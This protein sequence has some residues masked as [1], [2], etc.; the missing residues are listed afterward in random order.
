[1]DTLHRNALGRA[2]TLNG[3]TAISV[4]PSGRAVIPFTDPATGAQTQRT[5]K[6]FEYKPTYTGQSVT[7]AWDNDLNIVVVEDNIAELLLSR[8]WVANATDE[9]IAWWNAQAEAV[10]LAAAENLIASQDINSGGDDKKPADEG[11]KEPV[12]EPA[13]EPEPVAQPTPAP[14]PVPEPT[15]TP[16]P[17][18]TPEPAKAAAPTPPAG[19]RKAASQSDALARAEAEQSAAQKGGNAS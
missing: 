12:K 18:K 6:T 7:L 11:N 14:A 5:V 10:A 3:S 13:K 9:Q 1:M 8:R 2:I 15:P 4:K 17:V 16:E 19:R